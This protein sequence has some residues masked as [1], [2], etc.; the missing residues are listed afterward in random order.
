MSYIA[1]YIYINKNAQKKTL[2]TIVSALNTRPK[3]SILFDYE[4]KLKY[5]KRY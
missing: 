1:V 5:R 2:G 3:P 4:D